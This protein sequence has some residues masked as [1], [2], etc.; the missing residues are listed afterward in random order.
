[1]VLNCWSVCGNTL[2][3]WF[4]PAVS[5]LLTW[6]YFGYVLD[7]IPQIFPWMSLSITYCLPFF[8]RIHP[9]F[10]LEALPILFIPFLLSPSLQQGSLIWLAV[11]AATVWYVSGFRIRLLS[12]RCIL[13]AKGQRSGFWWESVW[14]TQHHPTVFWVVLLDCDRACHILVNMNLL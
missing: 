9:C 10:T 5:L 4:S 6:Q 3:S 14:M 7:N 11:L 12:L 1:M 8:L 13:Q 2:I